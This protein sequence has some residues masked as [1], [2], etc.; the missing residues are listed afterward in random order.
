M[1]ETSW[2]L[3]FPLSSLL[4]PIIATS[5]RDSPP[6]TAPI[7]IAY[8][9]LARIRKTGQY[10]RLLTPY[11]PLRGTTRLTPFVFHL[12]VLGRRS[13]PDARTSWEHPHATRLQL[14]A[15]SSASPASP[16]HAAAASYI[17]PAHHHQRRVILPWEHIAASSR[18]AALAAPR[19]L[20]LPRHR[21]PLQAHYHIAAAPVVHAPANTEKCARAD[22]EK[23][24]E[25]SAVRTRI[26][27]RRT[28]GWWHLRKRRLLHSDMKKGGRERKKDWGW[29]TEQVEMAMDGKRPDWVLMFS[30]ARDHESQ[31]GCPASI[32]FSGWIEGEQ[33]G[34]RSC[35]SIRALP[36]A[37]SSQ[38]RRLAPSFGRDVHMH[39]GEPLHMHERARMNSPERCQEGGQEDAM[40][41]QPIERR[42]VMFAET[43]GM[44][45]W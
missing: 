39:R 41:S 14:I 15:H 4:S 31:S 6:H 8:A 22:T 23:C 2:F 33:L 11:R 1:Q 24:V 20:A 35:R 12:L 32:T 37:R 43:E 44:V 18:S 45:T 16:P 21:P 7:P 17:S 30:E 19:T 34:E 27:K 9:S 10:R 3:T 13:N 28:G 38:T 25:R 5:H 40:E 36:G 29:S 42:Q 26:R